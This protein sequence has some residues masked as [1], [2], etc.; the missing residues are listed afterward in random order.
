[1][2][3]GSRSCVNIFC[4]R[5]SSLN[6]III[7][8]ERKKRKGNI[9]ELGPLIEPSSNDRIW[10]APANIIG[11]TRKDVSYKQDSAR[12][13]STHLVDDMYGICLFVSLLQQIRSLIRTEYAGYKSFKRTFSSCSRSWLHLRLFLVCTVDKLGISDSLPMIDGI[14][15]QPTSLVI[16]TLI[17]VVVDFKNG[18]TL[19]HFSLLN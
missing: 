13:F 6:V 1:M 2:D 16:T 4:T 10:S 5:T 15:V 14:R 17:R 9:P 12:R 11:W 8:R 7:I 19:Q 3:R 18:E